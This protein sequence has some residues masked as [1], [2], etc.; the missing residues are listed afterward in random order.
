MAGDVSKNG[1]FNKFVVSIMGAVT[2]FSAGWAASATT[3]WLDIRRID[4]QG[5]QKTQQLEARVAKV[6]TTMEVWLK[7]IQEQLKEINQELKSR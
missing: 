3:A 1:S 4:I 6:E 7:Q 5:S 2:L